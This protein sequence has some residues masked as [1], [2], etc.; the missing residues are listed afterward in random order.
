MGKLLS[1][2]MDDMEEEDYY[3]EKD[4]WA[5]WNGMDEEVIGRIVSSDALFASV[6]EVVGDDFT[7]SQVRIALEKRSFDAEGA[8][9][10]LLNPPAKAATK[11]KSQNSEKPAKSRHQ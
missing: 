1:D 5:A 2:A 8:V 7:E 11:K 9:D 10:Y 3:E 4:E 6:Y